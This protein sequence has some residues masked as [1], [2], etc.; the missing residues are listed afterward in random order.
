[1]NLQQLRY[2]KAL[3]DKGSFVAAANC[4]AVTQPTLSN[5]IA[6]L[7]MEL[8]HR[9]FRR[10][11]RTVKLTSYGEQLLP[12][13]LE[14][15]SL[16]ERLKASSKAKL[17][18]AATAAL[19]VGISPLVGVKRAGR[20]LASLRA[21]HPSVE[22]VFRESDLETLGTLLNR[23]LIDIMIAPYDVDPDLDVDRIFISLEHDP[24]LFLPKADD[25]AR[26]EGASSVSLY[27][28]APETFVLLPDGCG[29]TRVISKLFENSNLELRR[30]LGEASG[31]AGIKEFV[32]CSLAS[33]ILPRSKITEIDTLAVPI[34]QHGQPV[35]LQYFALGKPSTIAPD[36]FSQLWDTLLDENPQ[37]KETELSSGLPAT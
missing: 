5:G 15:L 29:L 13:I 8:G 17:D 4:C 7:E 25:R 32:D 35:S 16:F 26:W 27:D 33:G 9:L 18:T 11:T 21:K 1:M 19:Q 12:T 22:I 14:I 31:Y 34:V 3:V 2:V 36:L 37:I 28:I 24:L 6:Q 10:T 23:G 30:Y 20:I